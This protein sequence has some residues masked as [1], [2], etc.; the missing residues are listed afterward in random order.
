MWRIANGCFV[1]DQD[2]VEL[3]VAVHGNSRLLVEVSSRSFFVQWLMEK[4]R[5]MEES[6]MLTR[7]DGDGK[8][9]NH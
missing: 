1:N 5:M 9:Q 7:R 6:P 4:M 8:R 3:I 2:S